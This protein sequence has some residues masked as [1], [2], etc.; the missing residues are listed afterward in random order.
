MQPSLALTCV[1]AHRSGSM[2]AGCGDTSKVA[3]LPAL[4]LP[5]PTMFC[6]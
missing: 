6:I 4:L 2:G 1:A 5:D 3:H